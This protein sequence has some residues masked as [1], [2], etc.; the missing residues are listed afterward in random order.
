M[1]SIFFYFKPL[2]YR[3]FFGNRN[4]WFNS[5]FNIILNLLCL[6]FWCHIKKWTPIVFIIIFLWRDCYF[7]LVFC[8][9][10]FRITVFMLILLLII[11]INILV[12]LKYCWKSLFILIKSWS[13]KRTVLPIAKGGNPMYSLIGYFI[14]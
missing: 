12:I 4:S 3:T 8:Q 13:L 10:L 9:S 2:F 6:I 11:L 7:M 14:I 5:T 1:L